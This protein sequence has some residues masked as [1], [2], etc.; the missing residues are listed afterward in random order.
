V[1]LA[2]IA[3]S[4]F[5]GFRTETRLP[6]ASG[7]N[8]VDGRNGVGK[9]TLFDAVEFAL[10][11]Q[12]SKYGDS[13]AAGET[14]NDYL[15]WK[16][17][18]PPPATRFVEV[19]FIGEDGPLTIRRTPIEG[20]DAASL[21]A[22][23]AAMIHA[24][25]APPS[26]LTQLCASSIIRDELIAALSLDLSETDRYALLRQ[27]IG[28]GDAEL[29]IERGQSL[30]RAARRRSDETRGEVAA[31][32]AAVAEAQTR[33]DEVHAAL[34]PDAAVSTA[35]AKLSVL[36]GGTPDVPDQLV[37]AGREFVVR[38]EREL[39]DGQAVLDR[40]EQ[41]VAATAA[42]ANAEAKIDSLKKSLSTMEAELAA[43]PVEETAAGALASL[44]TELHQ[45]HK[46]G[47]RTGLLEGGCPLCAAPHDDASFAAGVLH[48]RQVMERLDAAAAEAV[49]RREA[50]STAEAAVA[51]RQGEL[52][53][54]SADVEG[55]S[56]QA[57]WQRLSLESIGAHPD[58]TQKDVAALTTARRAN[59]DTARHAIR[60]L[61]TLAQNVQLERAT[62]KLSEAR[63][64][65]SRAQERAMRS[66]QVE[67]AAAALH[68]ATRRAAGETLD[69][70]LQRVLPLMTELY[71][72]LRPH[73]F[74]Q[75]IEY[76]VRGDVRRFLSLQVGDGLNPQFLFSSGQRRA[77]GLAFLLSIHLSQAWSRWRTILLDDPVQH[78]DD[79]RT[80]N[81]AEMLAQLVAAGRQV[82]VAVEDAALA[83][84][85][86][87]RM[88]VAE[89]GA[90]ARLTL[91]LSPEGTSAL[92]ARHEL[93]PLKRGLL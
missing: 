33:L 41:T 43:L 89:P 38:L 61:G 91:G 63:Q 5:R 80:I 86:C 51:A 25:A 22:V 70:R 23:Q 20:P 21:A 31:A 19:T 18:G 60:I 27:A 53:R 35:S 77:T 30:A 26:P 37:A 1:K 69:L 64:R 15:W 11:G 83:D 47:D 55:W 9:S 48:A 65:L 74:W 3:I 16:G 85:L 71:G 72:R 45:L 67:V 34:T 40:W 66:R 76:S 62:T 84:L 13:K 49:R 10:T 75:D 82:I 81:L 28:A 6:L 4:G 44:V 29:W 54:L 50:I 92:V 32:T 14:V 68:D 58:A 73:P 90:A 93:V 52:A 46:V 2:E 78:V 7:F 87:R 24:D 39:K 12:L 88:P 17:S 57:E 56:K 36:V 42:L 59:L 8:V 79:F